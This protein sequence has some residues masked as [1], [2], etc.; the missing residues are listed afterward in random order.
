MSINKV[1]CS[2]DSDIMEYNQAYVILS[3][4]TSEEGLSLAKYDPSYIKVHPKVVEYYKQL[5]AKG[6][7]KK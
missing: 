2:I 1:I 7:G 3:R 5:G 4:C 6:E